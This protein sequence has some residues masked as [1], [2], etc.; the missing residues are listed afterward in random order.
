MQRAEARDDEE[1]LMNLLQLRREA[2]PICR[3]WGP[4]DGLQA[5]GGLRDY[6]AKTK[7]CEAVAEANAGEGRGTAVRR[8]ASM[9]A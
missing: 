1:N 9:L 8:H 4:C 3:K 5:L 2:K 6:C 7:T